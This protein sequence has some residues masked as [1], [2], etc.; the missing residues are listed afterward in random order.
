MIKTAISQLNLKLGIL[1]LLHLPFRHL[2]MLFYF[3]YRL[4]N[5]LTKNETCEQNISMQNIIELP[6]VLITLFFLCI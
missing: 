4:E 2:V 3:E 5:Q 1:F 6:F